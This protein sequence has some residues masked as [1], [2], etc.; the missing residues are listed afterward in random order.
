M[1]AGFIPAEHWVQD[2]AVGGGR[3]IGEA[4]HLIDL[5]TYLTDSIV[6]SV[7]MNAMGTDPDS[8]TDN[9]SILLKYKN[10]SNGV[11]NYFA[12]GHKAYSKERIEVYSQGRTI[13]MD[14]FRKSKYYGFKS[15]GMSKSQDKGHYNQFKLFIDNLKKDG[16]PTI[17]FDQV[18]NTSRAAIAAVESLQNGSWVN[19]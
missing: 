5:I 4:C 9:A 3:I 11:I 1:N 7:V 13:V 18:M 10:G 6:E 15:S 2:M 16:S 14:N 19:V 17:P 12:N 8:G